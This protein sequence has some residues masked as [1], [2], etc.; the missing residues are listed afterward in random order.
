MS[1]SRCT[2]SHHAHADLLSS[3]SDLPQRAHA[4][5]HRSREP[6]RHDLNSPSRHLLSVDAANLKSCAQSPCNARPGGLG[7]ILRWRGVEVDDTVAEVFVRGG[8]DGGSK[9]FR[10]A[11]P[12][13]ETG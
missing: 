13:G 8:H 2:P 7:L 3:R 10:S 5:V 9:R 6:L 11:W 1:R 12:P 4:R